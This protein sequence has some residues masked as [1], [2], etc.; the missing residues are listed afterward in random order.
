MPSSKKSV[1]ARAKIVRRQQ[2]W[3][4]RPN[5]RHAWDRPSLETETI[6]REN[7]RSILG[8]LVAAGMFLDSEFVDGVLTS[9]G[10]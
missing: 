9:I 1:P 6:D 7:A 3:S 8:E 10:E 4:G 5:H 2:R